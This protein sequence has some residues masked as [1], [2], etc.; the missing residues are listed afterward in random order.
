M[1]HGVIFSTFLCLTGTTLAAPIHSQ[2]QAL[3]GRQAAEVDVTASAYVPGDAAQFEQLDKRQVDFTASGDDEAEESVERRFLAGA[4]V[5]AEAAAGQNAVFA[6]VEGSGSVQLEQLSKRQI[7]FTASVDDEAEA[8]VEHRFLSGLDVSA[9]A[10]AGQNAAFANVEGSG[11]A[12]LERLVKRQ[13]DFTA[14][15]EGEEAQGMV[16]RAIADVNAGSPPTE[17]EK[18]AAVFVNVADEVKAT[19]GGQKDGRLVDVQLDL[20]DENKKSVQ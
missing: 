11:S 6:N 19:V 5:S 1:R 10:A 13:V 2:S 3:A 20:N 4:D 16:E 17:D 18:D 14:S 12:Q 15:V 8:S 7:D 9:E